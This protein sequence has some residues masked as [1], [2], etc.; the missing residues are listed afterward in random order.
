MMN[1]ENKIRTISFFIT[2]VVMFFAFLIM[3]FCG[4]YSQYPPPLAKK[5]IL[6]EFESFEGGGGGVDLVYLVEGEVFERD[7]VFA[8]PHGGE[9]YSLRFTV[10]AL[11][12]RWFLLFAVFDFESVAGGFFGI[13]AED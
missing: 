4:L 1:A 9:V 10:G 5:V 2:L 11:P 8:V 13:E 3:Y 12:R 7:E 6:I